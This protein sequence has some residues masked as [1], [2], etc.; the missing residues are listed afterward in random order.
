MNRGNGC[1]VK[2]LGKEMLIT[3]TRESPLRD[4]YLYAQ[5]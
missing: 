1:C 2:F 4:K 5:G 3:C